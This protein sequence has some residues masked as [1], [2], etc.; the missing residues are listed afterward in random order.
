MQTAWGWLTVVMTLMANT[1][2]RFH[3]VSGSL[4]SSRVL[5]FP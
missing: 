5:R 1:P 3:H 2:E 4:F